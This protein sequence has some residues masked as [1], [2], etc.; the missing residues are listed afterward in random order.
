MRTVWIYE[1]GEEMKVFATKE[2]A[3]A[4]FEEH[5]P[6]GVAFEHRVEGWLAAGSADQHGVPRATE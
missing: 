4:W 2:A 6:E 5:D 1:R 3:Q